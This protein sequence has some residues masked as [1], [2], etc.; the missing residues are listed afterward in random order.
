MSPRC[1]IAAIL[2]ATAIFC[3]AHES[4]S[5][6]YSNISVGGG[7]A[8]P[9]APPIQMPPP[10]KPP[11]ASAQAPAPA[12]RIQPV[13][14]PT[15][16]PVHPIGAR[17]FLAALATAAATAWIMRRR[18]GASRR[19]NSETLAL[20]AHE[21]QSPLAAIE[22]Y[23]DLMASEAPAQ[24]REARVWLEDLGRMR[25]TTTHLRRTIGD[26][27]DMTRVEDGRMKLSL[28]PIE[29]GPLLSAA[30][31]AYA[32][33]AAAR[34]V[35]LKLV[36]APAPIFALADPDRL[37]QVLDNL[38]GNAVKF[39]PSGKSVTLA[40]HADGDEAFIE[41]SDEGVGVPAGK[42]DRLFGKFQRLGPAV[43]GTEGT[44]LG[45][46][47]SR[48]LIEAQNGNLQYEPVRDGGSLFRV[49]LP[50]TEQA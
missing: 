16:P 46:Y 24:S 48:R 19:A 6:H 8:L 11:K 9:A 40:A 26:I 15:P 47:L 41:V 4:G 44:G 43:D 33:H 39:T 37:R 29:L 7:Q 38:L 32:P 23:L 1:L 30:S 50:K 17:W 5:S 49:T 25:T 20:A 13:A 3:R 2:C 34:G 28:R 22:S 42:R 27:L 18:E 35:R 21:L 14:T 36:A 45:L 12:A 31:A 10:R